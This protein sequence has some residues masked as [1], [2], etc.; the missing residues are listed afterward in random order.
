[1]TDLKYVWK[2]ASTQHITEWQLYTESSN[3]CGSVA[4]TTTHHTITKL[5]NETSFF[6]MIMLV[7]PVIHV[8]ILLKAK[9]EGYD[10]IM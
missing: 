1:M 9:D 3:V 5:S 7:F 2:I 8:K 10:K 6:V 4:Q